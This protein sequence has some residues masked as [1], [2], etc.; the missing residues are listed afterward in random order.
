MGTGYFEQ[1]LNVH[2]RI[3]EQG[4][5]LIARVGGSSEIIPERRRGTPVRGNWPPERSRVL[6]D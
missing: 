5:M 2:S 4:T 6:T 3:A 1:D